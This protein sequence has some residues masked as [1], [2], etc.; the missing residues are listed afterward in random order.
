MQEA[1]LLTRRHALRVGYAACMGLSLAD[2]L[3]AEEAAGAAGA[4]EAPAQ[5]VIHIFLPGGLP[6]QDSFDPKPLSAGQYRGR[7]GTIQTALPGVQFCEL[8][9]RLA[10]IAERLTIVRSMTHVE[11]DHDRG[12][13]YM[14]TGARPNPAIQFP[15]VGS[16]VAKE[17]G[18]RNGLPPYIWYPLDPDVFPQSGFLNA[19]YNPLSLGSEA[20][21]SDPASAKYKVR[22]ISL[23]GDVSTE[24]NARRH[25]LLSG[26][27]QRFIQA[28]PSERAKA[29]DKFH[30]RAL[31]M[32]TSEA[33]QQ[34]FL[35]DREPPA[36]RARYGDNSAGQGLL[37]ARR[38]VEAGVRFVSLCYPPTSPGSAGAWDLHIDCQKNLES[39][40]PPID[41]ALAVLIQDLEERGRLASTLVVLS[42]EFGRTPKINPAAGRDHWSKVFSIALAGGGMKPGVVYGA[43][44]ATAADPSDHPVTV[45]DLVRTMY[46][47][48]GIDANHELIAPGDRPLRLVDGG[49]VLT[50]LLARQ[51]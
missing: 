16:I 31:E 10:A 12:K 27:N 3:R 26:A 29:V 8:F 42:T 35:I 36:M 44:N 14:Y 25:R 32:V 21:I 2:V 39:I 1:L 33:A 18:P 13:M 17:L 40:A 11:N 5:S 37:L 7:L 4:L 6:Q 46:R 19:A 22:D 48:I 47:Q 24:R 49:R 43:S 41:Q 30:E 9:P 34:A 23:P 28:H 15:S 51:T 38:L 50:E 20:A 45:E